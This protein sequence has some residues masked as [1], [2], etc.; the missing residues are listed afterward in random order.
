MNFEEVLQ[1]KKIHAN[2]M[3]YK[4]LILLQTNI[5]ETLLKIAYEKEK[6]E[7]D[8][9]LTNSSINIYEKQLRQY[10]DDYEMIVKSMR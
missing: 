4:Q 3:H 1:F 9:R 6:V 8:P 2:Y 5:H 7:M 10:Y